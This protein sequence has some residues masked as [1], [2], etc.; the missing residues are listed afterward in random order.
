[1]DKKHKKMKDLGRIQSLKNE[2]LIV[3][4]KCI[5]EKKIYLKGISHCLNFY[6]E[7]HRKTR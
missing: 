7:R 6:S 5:D 4:E 3:I 1:M 2:T